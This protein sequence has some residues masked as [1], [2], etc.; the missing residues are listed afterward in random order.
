M[1]QGLKPTGARAQGEPAPTHTG[2]V[3]TNPHVLDLAF[4]DLSA[5]QLYGLLRLRSDVFVVEQDC[6]YS[7]L[8]G[9]DAAPTTRH[10]WVADTHEDAD[11]AAA[12]LRVLAGSKAGEV[13]LGRIVT[14]SD[15]RGRGLAAHL[16]RVAMER[17]PGT[18]VIHAQAHLSEWY[19]QFGF[20]EVGEIFL[21]DGIDHIEMRT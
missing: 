16:I 7:D 20:A 2:G 21:E 4:A 5:A 12:C 9:R 11:P 15:V 14:R 17:Y 6:V 8:D 1:V 10:L 3:T 13:I 19:A 18:H